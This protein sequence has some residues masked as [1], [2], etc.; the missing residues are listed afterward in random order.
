MALRDAGCT[1]TG[2]SD[3]T[4]EQLQVLELGEGDEDE[5]EG[6][7]ERDEGRDELA[8]EARSAELDEEYSRVLSLGFD[9]TVLSLG[10]E[11]TE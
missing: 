8:A 11:T 9:Q 7:P 4:L 6:E 2:A 1:I 5:E 10:L 3:P